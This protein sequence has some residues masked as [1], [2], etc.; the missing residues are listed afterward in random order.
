MAVGIGIAVAGE[1]PVACADT[2]PT[3][4]DSSARHTASP[5]R[6]DPV[7]GPGKSVTS[8]PTR[9]QKSATPVAPWRPAGAD[10]SKT[11]DHAP[12]ST[13]DQTAAQGNST[14]SRHAAKRTASQ[15]T[16]AHNEPV[17][18]TKIIR[19]DKSQ[20]T[21]NTLAVS[22]APA[23]RPPA[24]SGTSV[25]AAMVATTPTSS[26]DTTASRTPAPL[27]PIAKI[28][29]L[30][31]RIVNAVMQ[32]FGLTGSQSGPRSLF[33]WAPIDQ[34]L[35][36]AF[37]GLEN[38][39][40]LNRTPTDQ[41]AVS[42]LTYTGP[43]DDVTP[44]VAQFLNA[45]AGEYVLGGQPGGLKPFTVNGFQMQLFNPVSG[46]AGRVWVTPQ[47]QLIIAYQGTTGGT[48][49]LFHPLIA[50]PQIISDGLGIFTR[51]TPQAF[52]D[53]VAF[54]KRV[55]VQ[56]RKQGYSTGDIFL[57][58]HSLGAWEAEYVAQQTGRAGVGFEAPGLNTKVPGNGAN[59]GFVNIETYGDSAAYVSTDLP[60]LQPFMPPYVPGGGSKP[61][62]GSIVMLG[63]PND[64]NRLHNISKLWGL[65]PI[66]DLIFAIDVLL[67]FNTHHLPGMQAYNLGIAPDPTE[68]PWYGL[69]VGP[70]RDWGS[71]TIGQLQQAASDTG[72]LIAP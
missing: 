30:P 14:H 58:G 12:A 9:H 42:T 16:P 71:L 25:A 15:R 61:H 33:N 53:S 39:F 27:S 36:A 22:S 10:T 57:T 18:A 68:F 50:I 20:T 29:T 54:E 24:S 7:R 51:A 8:K 40:G 23:Q 1:H 2:G 48:R 35:F 31:G 46:A 44:T 34:V 41:P 59:S 69:P 6:T 43:T 19:A 63:D 66:H 45:A 28:L 3:D 38:L 65:N 67:N 32:V 56:A 72:V 64:V 55:E 5:F 11:T 17:A 4:T 49:L 26:T 62:Y 21:R 47:N 37:R 70:V 52:Y 13:A 60:G